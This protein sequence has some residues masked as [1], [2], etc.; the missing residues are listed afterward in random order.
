LAAGDQ[1]AGI[2][3]TIGDASGNR[4]ANL[5]PFKI[6]LGLF[7][8]RLGRSDSAGSVALSRLSRVNSCST[9]PT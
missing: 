2:D 9:S 5:G 6:K 4:R 3:A 1:I 8:G 7:E